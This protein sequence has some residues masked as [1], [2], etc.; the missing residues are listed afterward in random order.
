MST[1]HV[2]DS[3][4]VLSR[5]RHRTPRSG[6]CFMEMASVLAGERW[7]DHPECTEPLLAELARLVND[8]TSDTDRSEL[9]VLIPSVVGLRGGGTRTE[10]EITAA[11]AAYAVGRSPQAVQRALAAGLLSVQR[12]LDTIGD[13]EPGRGTTRA[14]V[15]RMLAEVPAEAG[16][17]RRFSGGRP[18]STKTFHKRVAPTVV[19]AAV[20]GIRAAHPDSDPRLRR[21]LEVG[22][23]AARRARAA[24]VEAAPSAD[25]S[26]TN[27]PAERR[28]IE[29][30]SS[31]PTEA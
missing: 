23:D 28:N 20:R 18:I 27:P 31:S 22:I 11:V 5:G 16:W 15:E 2:P 4:P 3:L 21:L 14:D 1:F 25:A 9:A 29:G 13:P 6:A 19:R 17:A 10:V 24:S 7:S 30:L 12:V 8:N 26:C